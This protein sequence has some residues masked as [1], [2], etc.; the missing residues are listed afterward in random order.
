MRIKGSFGSLFF[1]WFTYLVFTDNKKR[2]RKPLK[3]FLEIGVADFDTLLPLAE[4]G[5]WTGWCVEPMPH[6]AE[7]L[8][9]KAKDLPVAICECAISDRTGSIQMAVGG[10]EQ[11]AS[12]A[13]HVI[14]NNHIGAQLLNMPVNKHL[15]RGEIEVPCMTLDDFID[16]HH[17]TEIDFLKIDVEGHE[18]TILLNYSWRVKPKLIKAEHK[19][20]PGDLLRRMIEPQGYSIFVET[21]DLY[22]VL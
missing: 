12:G 15:R 19:H 5:G 2:V 16:K 3:T 13:S 7:T 21:Y 22:C 9:E 4:K 8:R 20:I 6:F 11:W 18:P 14:D 1:L 17:I 10:G